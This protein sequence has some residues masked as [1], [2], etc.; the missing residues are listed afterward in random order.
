M[1]IDKLLFLLFNDLLVEVCVKW[2]EVEG[3]NVFVDYFIVEVVI[4]FK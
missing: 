4:V 1:V 3:C 2:L